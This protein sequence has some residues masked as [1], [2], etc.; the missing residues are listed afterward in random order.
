MQLNKTCIMIVFRRIKT[1]A[2]ATLACLSGH[3]LAAQ[4]PA[5]HYDPD[6]LCK[7]IEAEAD[8]HAAK[9]AGTSGV[10][11]ND[12]DIHYHRCEW[13]VDPAVLYINGKVT[14][15]FE[16]TV[17]NFSLL[18]FHLEDVL[19]VDSVHYHGGNTTFSQSGGVLGIN[20]PLMSGAVLDSVTIWYHGVPASSGFGSFIQSTHGSNV[21]IIWT[22]SEPFGGSDWWPCKDDLNDKADS[23]DVLI[24]TPAAYRGASNG[25]LVNE[26]QQ[27]PNKTYHW[28]HR[29][30]IATYLICL[31][32]TNYAQFTHQVPLPA[33][34]LPV[35]NY[36]FPEDSATA[37]TETMDIIPL[38]QLY[39]S[40]FGHYPFD[41]EK[42]GH[43]QFG[44]G[45]GMEHQT[46]T[47]MSMYG[48]EL[49]AHELAHQWFGDKVTTGSW[50]DIW[51]NEGFATYLSGL[52]YEHLLGGVYWMPFKQ[53][54]I[55]NVTSTPD[56]SVWCNDT[57]TVL[58]IFNGRLTY[59]KGAMILHQLRWI[60]GDQNF[61]TAIRNYINDPG[62]SYSFARTYDLKAHLEAV[63][64][65]S[66]TWYFDDWFYG[67][68]YPRYHL[69]Y[70]SLNG[71]FVGS[72]SQLQSHAS[73]GFFQMPVPVR[74]FYNNGQDT[75]LRI[76]IDS[77]NTSFSIP[78][79]PNL[80]SLDS[81]Q[82][83]PDFWLISANNTTNFFVIDGVGDSNLDRLQVY[84]VPTQD[85][86]Q[87][88]FG[89]ALGQVEL[90]LS[91]LQGRVLL[92]RSLR[93]LS[94]T[95]LSLGD[96]AP[97]VYGLRVLSGD[98]SV[99]RKV[100]IQ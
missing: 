100:V 5:H 57:T 38:I 31:A 94:S 6:A 55:Q 11:L 74:V 33:G 3:F 97:G 15:Y 73:V 53:G 1:F 26:T 59:N 8:A 23:L 93:G 69:E 78:L 60:M 44:W 68:G 20:L 19:T 80:F 64:G 18:R 88:D 36:V 79:S 85:R 58:R 16:A 99:V 22:L 9:I 89:R 71:D 77:V 84:P 40:L 50:E 41:A 35:L 72:F 90:E 76:P 17:P 81:V 96:V 25:L 42:Y 10:V 37:F 14:T 43:A 75:L 24:T 62:L 67:Q 65:Q 83:D 30:P 63:H 34:N 28:R 61:F 98:R 52:A 21:P 48:F 51:L 32:V 27:G 29:Y 95:E 7:I 92:R 46:M 39:D 54:H 13:E 70:S 12:Y 2:L 47:F 56:G 66:L 49:Q 4:H 82:I 45:G 91:D 87:I 86:L